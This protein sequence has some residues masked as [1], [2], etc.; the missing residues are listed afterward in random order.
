MKTKQR[1]KPEPERTT[2]REFIE[3]WQGSSSVKEVA[4]KTGLSKT[5]IRTRACRYRKFGVPLKEYEPEPLPDWEELA[6]YAAS[7]VTEEPGPDDAEG[8][9]SEATAPG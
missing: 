7:L 3:A 4:R 6:A 5:A 8:Q 2:P 1:R 9:A